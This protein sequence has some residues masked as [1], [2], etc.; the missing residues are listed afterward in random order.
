[1]LKKVEPTLNTAPPALSVPSSKPSI[2]LKTAPPALGP[3]QTNTPQPQ[4]ASALVPN[5]SSHKSKYWQSL[6]Q[7]AKDKDFKDLALAQNVPNKS[8]G[9]KTKEFTQPLPTQ[10]QALWDRREFL[11]LMTASVALAGFGCVRRPAEKIVPYVKRPENMVLGKANFYSSSYYDGEEGFGLLVKTREGRPIKIEGNPDHPINQGGLSARA[12]SHILSLYDPERLKHPQ[13][14]LFNKEK[15]NRE[16]IS[17]QYSRVDPEIVKH[18]KQNK[19]AFLTGEWPSPASTKLLRT[20]CQKTKAQHFVWNPLS[21]HDLSQAQELCYGKGLV[22]R[23]AL[24][25]A[26]LILSIDC[27]FLGSWLYPTEFN[28]LYSRAR[29]AGQ[30]MNRLIVF[31]SLLSLTGTNAD[32]RFRIKPSQQLDL[33]LSIAHSLIEQGF[34]KGPWPSHLKKPAKAPWQK[35]SL[36]QKNW[37]HL[38]A[39]LWQHRGQSLVLTGGPQTKTKQA[40]SLQVAVTWLNHLLENDGKTVDYANAYNTWPWA[41]RDIEKLISLIEQ[42]KI[43]TLII[44]KTNPLYTYPDKGRLNQALKKL[45]MVVY[46]GDREDET[47]RLAHYILPDHHDLEKWS[48]WEFQ[49][50]VLS[51]QQP[52]IRPLYKTRAFEQALLSWL[53]LWDSKSATSS[54][55]SQILILQSLSLQLPNKKIL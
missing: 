3:K 2:E 36:S 13:Q 25:R 7:W 14:N 42:G 40:Q 33:A 50:G 18:L 6:E 24:D 12:H 10:Q 51:I 21:P 31:E 27:D 41:V 34:S 23:F 19:A 53:F 15:T 38:I 5:N 39:E 32:Q 29:Q 45:D 20:F 30:D 22:P 54:K 26:R 43:N 11:Q 1:M 48:D 8:L 37:E 28:R 17:A 49:K 16:R 9:Q 46:T 47:G 55:S 44:H 4:N 52:T 35:F